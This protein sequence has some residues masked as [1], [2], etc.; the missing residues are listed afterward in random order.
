MSVSVSFLLSSCSLTRSWECKRY[1]VRT[2]ARQVEIMHTLSSF[3][4]NQDQKMHCRFPVALPLR[5]ANTGSGPTASTSTC[6]PFLQVGCVHFASLQVCSLQPGHTLLAQI[7]SR[8]VSTS[9][10]T[11][12]CYESGRL[13]AQHSENVVWLL[14]PFRALSL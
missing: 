9:P 10:P 2:G 6:T 7:R 13:V 3:F 11:L 8:R 5:L 1:I 14:Q 4:C 12:Q